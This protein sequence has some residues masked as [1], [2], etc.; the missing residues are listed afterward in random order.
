MNDTP[1]VHAHPTKKKRR[2]TAIDW[3]M[4]RG[5]IAVAVGVFVGAFGVARYAAILHARAWMVPGPPCPAMSPAQLHASGRQLGKG[6]TYHG[7][8]FTRAYG[9]VNCDEVTPDLLGLKTVPV[10]QF[11]SPTVLQ[12]TTGGRTFLYTTPIRPMTV[13]VADG[14]P[15]C[16]L[17]ISARL[18]VTELTRRLARG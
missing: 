6:F 3:V 4:S 5:G 2:R 17:N 12:V 11:N 7:V 16:V 15:Q 1:M 14:A 8:T 18:K 9:Y 13:W 10:C